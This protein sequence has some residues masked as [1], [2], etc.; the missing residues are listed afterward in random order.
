VTLSPLIPEPTSRSK[1][2]A[3]VPAES[4]IRHL[5]GL[6]KLVSPQLCVLVVRSA[7][8]VQ[9]ECC[10]A[11]RALGH[12]V[13][14]L[15]LS[16]GTD[17]AHVAAAVDQLLR[18]VVRHR[19]DM[20]LTMN[21]LG[22]DTGGHMAEVVE[23]LGLPTAI[24]FVDNP[25]FAG[26]GRVRVPPEYTTLFTWDRSF[27]P[28]LADA[29][30]TDVHHLPLATDL[31]TFA[32]ARTTAPPRWATTFVGSSLVDLQDKW[33]HRLTALEREVAKRMVPQLCSDR[34]AMVAQSNLAGPAPD[35]HAR[36]L[37]YANFIASKD[38][39]LQLLCAL[40]A[41]DLTVFGDS[42][43]QALLPNAT[44]C[45]GFDY[46]PE[47]AHVY[48]RS[49]VN[50]NATNLQMPCTVNQRVFDVP[51]AGGL[52]LTDRQPELED[53]F[54]PGQE[55]LVYDGPAQAADL[56]TYYAAHPEAGQA[57]VFAAQQRIAA[58]HTYR[59][60]LRQLVKT[61]RQAHARGHHSRPAG[62]GA[63]PITSAPGCDVG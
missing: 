46:G 34:T 1:A 51:A 9:R 11:L 53:Y 22:F 39:R 20:L 37:A 6:A 8:H 31:D 30:D 63:K 58:H 49:A 50:F 15:E 17:S 12:R 7:Y 32:G 41:G 52:L 14:T 45:G 35:A 5:R 43:W 57:F 62:A 23:A 26:Q 28:L 59:H 47:L 55:V 38:Y 4:P 56:A 16:D 19:P 3:L 40:S 33:H 44:T 36:V 2:A 27:V 25:V 42:G 21:Y 54:V 29:T 60:R 61:M 48:A 10:V 13:I 18:A 24:W